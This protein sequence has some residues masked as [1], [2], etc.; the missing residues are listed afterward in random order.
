MLRNTRPFNI[1]GL[2][3]ISIPCGITNTGL[4]VGMQITG[5]PWAEAKVLRLAQAYERQTSWHVRRPRQA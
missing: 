3:T 2:P 4:P 5:A 1:L